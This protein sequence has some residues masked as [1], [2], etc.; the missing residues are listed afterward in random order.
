VLRGFEEG[1][2]TFEPTY[3][4]ELHGFGYD[5]APDE[6]GTLVVTRTPFWCDRVLWSSRVSVFSESVELQSYWR[7]EVLASDHRPVSATF[8]VG[9][10][11]VDHNR[12]SEVRGAVQR[13][14]TRREP[15]LAP[16]IRTSPASLAL[17]PVAYASPY[18]ARGSCRRWCGCVRAAWRRGS[19]CTHRGWPW[20]IGAMATAAPAAAVKTAAVTTAS[21]TAAWCVLEIGR[22]DFGHARS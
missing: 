3:K 19:A 18:E 6:N 17:G 13:G 9:F 4:H 10:E 5:R 11:R 22:R 2:L 21:V 1:A 15:Q 8:A 16:R 14:L 7:Q 12:R 20:P